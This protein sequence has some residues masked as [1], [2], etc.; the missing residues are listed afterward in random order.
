MSFQKYPDTCGRGLNFLFHKICPLL[1]EFP[2]FADTVLKGIITPSKNGSDFNVSESSDE[3]IAK[4]VDSVTGS[5]DGD[6]SDKAFKGL[7]DFAKGFN[8]TGKDKERDK[9]KC[10]T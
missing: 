4:K 8:S 9:G 6:Y 1:M 7:H 10:P 3:Q 5:D 2:F